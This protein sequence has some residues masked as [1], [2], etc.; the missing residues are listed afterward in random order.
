MHSLYELQSYLMLPFF[1]SEL[2][3]V[4]DTLQ[5]FHLQPYGSLGTVKSPGLYRENAQNSRHKHDPDSLD[6]ESGPVRANG[7]PFYLEGEEDRPI[8]DS[9]FL[10]C[11]S[12]FERLVASGE[13]RLNALKSSA[14]VERES[15]VGLLVTVNER[16]LDLLELEKRL[17]LQPGHP[18]QQGAISLERSGS[19]A[20][21]ELADPGSV[22]FGAWGERSEHE[23]VALNFINHGLVDQCFFLLFPIAGKVP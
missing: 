15:Q 7:E 20:L 2:V 8:D 5:R 3:D 14:K 6:W 21:S 19:G 22:L 1:F 12:I 10:G 9:D 11:H 16:T 18:V 23:L 17:D 13:Y 4:R